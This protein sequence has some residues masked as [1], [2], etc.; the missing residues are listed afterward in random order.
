MEIDIDAILQKLDSEKQ[1]RGELKL[2]LNNTEKEIEK[3]ELQLQ[4]VLT[5]LD[6]EEMQKGVYWFGWKNKTRKAFDQALF[7]S[8]HPDLLE[9]YKVE[10]TSKVFELK[11]GG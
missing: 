2:Y 6:V 5:S 1:K 8:E 7:G 11:I 10:K 9:K 3:L 4:A